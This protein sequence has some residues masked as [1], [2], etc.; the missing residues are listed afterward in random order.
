MTS[1]DMAHKIGTAI[2]SISSGVSAYLFSEMI[3]SELI[4]I[5]SSC[6]I[7]GLGAFIGFYLTKAMKQREEY[8]RM[9][10]EE[11]IR[12][13]EEEQRIKEELRKRVLLGGGDRSE[14]QEE[15][16]KNQETR[17]KSPEIIHMGK[18]KIRAQK[19][20]IGNDEV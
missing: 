3:I 16:D 1:S 4:R 8:L 17:D 5:L 11:G 12:L 18:I 19:K 15:R 14:K 7:A 13:W 6:I 9:K 2:A 10:R 20:D